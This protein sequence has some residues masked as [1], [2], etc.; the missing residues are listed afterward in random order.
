MKQPD[1]FN[2]YEGGAPYWILPSGQETYDYEEW[3]RVDKEYWKSINKQK[4]KDR[5]LQSQNRLE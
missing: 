2:G 4:N 1:G 3:C 5:T